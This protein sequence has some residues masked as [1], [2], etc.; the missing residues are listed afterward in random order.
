[1]S[2][3]TYFGRV[4]GDLPPAATESVTINLACG[5]ACGA[6]GALPR[7]ADGWYSALRCARCK[8]RRGVVSIATSRT[9][10]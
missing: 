3:A 7:R 10:R 9:R 6:L 8:R 2:D 4:A 1:M 5:H